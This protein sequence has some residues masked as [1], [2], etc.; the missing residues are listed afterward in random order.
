[1]FAE[2]HDAWDAHAGQTKTAAE[3][4]AVQEPFGSKS[5]DEIDFG[6][7]V[8][9]DFETN[10]LLANGRLRPDFHVVSS[11]HCW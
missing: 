10:F 4:A 7:E 11:S 1:V 3:T 6:R 9:G 2:A 5:L 8:A